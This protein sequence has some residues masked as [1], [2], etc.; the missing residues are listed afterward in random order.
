MTASFW[1]IYNITASF[2]EYYVLADLTVYIPKELDCPAVSMCF[3][4]RELIKERDLIG[5]DVQKLT[6]SEIL[7]LTPNDSLIDRCKLRLPGKYEY[8]EYQGKNCSDQFHIVKFYVQESICYMFN[9]KQ[10]K[11]KYLYTTITGAMSWPGM[12]FHFT[13]DLETFNTSSIIRPIIHFYEELPFWSH[14]LAMGFILRDAESKDNMTLF[15]FGSS[16]IQLTRATL[17]APYTTNCRNYPLD[18]FRSSFNCEQQCL[19]NRTIE[20]A[21]KV[22]FTLILDEKLNF[23]HV[24]YEDLDDPN[25]RALVFKAQEECDQLCSQIN[26]T[27]RYSSTRTVAEVDGKEFSITF[28]AP[29]EMFFDLNSVP[30]LLLIEYWIH[31]LSILGTSFGLN[32][33]QANP[34]KMSLI[35]SLRSK[36]VGMFS[37]TEHAEMSTCRHCSQTKSILRKELRNEIDLR[38]ASFPLM[39]TKV[40]N[41]NRRKYSERFHYLPTCQ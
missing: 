33:F 7:T 22:P 41:S 30:K 34:F 13:L 2:L 36:L 40:K 24:Q 3:K 32:M 38:L 18:G 23:P 16:Y 26:C 15:R 21:G 10:A 12:F 14:K 19:I 8:E 25:R 17:E 5:K 37:K 28:E 29:N 11:S 6:I 31:C 39:S 1:Q 27:E 35:A 9:F 4:Y 20:Y